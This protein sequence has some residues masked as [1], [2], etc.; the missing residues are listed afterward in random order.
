LRCC[1]SLAGIAIGAAL[2]LGAGAEIPPWLQWLP[3]SSPASA[4][5]YRLVPGLEGPVS[6]RR[7]P[8]ETA[9]E[10]LEIA[11]ALASDAALIALAAREYEAALDFVNAERLWQRFANASS[12]PVAGQIALADYYH[13]RLQPERELAA[14][15][16]ADGALPA[17]DDPLMPPEAQRSWGLHER[18]QSLVALDALGV[19]AAT[20]DYDAWIDKYPEEAA[21]YE[22][23]FDFL[24]EHELIDEADVLLARYTAMFPEDAAF[25]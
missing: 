8:E 13:R 5:L 11:D 7:P 17:I 9:P 14:L 19:P 4:V 25:P 2:V 16:D 15:R 3:A 1:R 20:D 12:D 23:Y 10:L 22:R 18:V 21:L 6:I 24:I